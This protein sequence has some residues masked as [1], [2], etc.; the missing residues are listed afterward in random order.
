MLL[1]KHIGVLINPL[2]RRANYLQ[3]FENGN[4][5]E[6][7]LRIAN[8]DKITDYVRRQR[9]YKIISDYFLKQP[10]FLR[11]RELN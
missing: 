2:K 10:I 1:Y 6:F 9:L 5:R 3:E 4:Y 11:N 8:T 7:P